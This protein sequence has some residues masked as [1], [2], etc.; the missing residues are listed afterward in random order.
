MNFGR[1]VKKIQPVTGTY[2]KSDCFS[3]P[4]HHPLLCIPLLPVD[5]S[6]LQDRLWLMLPSVMEEAFPNG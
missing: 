5:N 1:G 6:C 3:K 2:Q 4:L